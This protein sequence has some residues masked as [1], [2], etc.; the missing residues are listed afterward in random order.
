LVMHQPQQRH[1]RQQPPDALRRHRR[2]RPPGQVPNQIERRERGLYTTHHSSLT[3]TALVEGQVAG[4]AK[5]LASVVL[6]T[7]VGLALA[8]CHSGWRSGR[9]ISAERVAGRDS[10]EMLTGK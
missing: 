7:L 3:T 1:L 10:R 9:A 8:I 4:D 6:V 2:R 5:F